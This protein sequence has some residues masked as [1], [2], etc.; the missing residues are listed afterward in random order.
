VHLLESLAKSL[1]DNGVKPH[2]V[3]FTAYTERLDG[4]SRIGKSHLQNKQSMHGLKPLSFCF[5]MSLQKPDK[6]FKIPET[7]FPDF[8]TIYRDLWSQKIDPEAQVFTEDT[9]EGALN[10]AR[11]IG[12]QHG[13]AGGMQTLITGSLHLVGGAL[14]ILRPYD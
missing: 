3:I 1:S 4:K 8:P 10:L 9:I 11:K 7:P 12:E 2:T 5:L 6:T 13:S 14:N